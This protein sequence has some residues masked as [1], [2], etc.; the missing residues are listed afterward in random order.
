VEEDCAR[1]HQ[2]EGPLTTGSLL[3]LAD[4]LER[5]VDEATSASSLA[6]DLRLERTEGR[7]ILGIAENI[8][9]AVSVGTRVLRRS[10]QARPPAGEARN[11][12]QNDPCCSD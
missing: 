7:P 12:Q 10:E 5:A 6:Q 4:G 2:G 1:I 3:L 9:P 8:C 11:R